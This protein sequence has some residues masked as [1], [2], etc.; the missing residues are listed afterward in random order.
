M[1]LDPSS[2]QPVYVMADILKVEKQNEKGV[3]L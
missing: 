1:K 3:E 2:L